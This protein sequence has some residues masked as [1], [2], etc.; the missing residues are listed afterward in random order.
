MGV[1][2]ALA[3]AGCSTLS[4]PSGPKISVSLALQHSP[5]APT[6]IR[7]DIGGQRVEVTSS[8]PSPGRSTDVRGRGYGATPV[9]VVLLTTDGDSLAAVA[10][11]QLFQRDH[12]HWVAALV[13]Q[14]R[15]V[16]HCIGTLVAAPLGAG[17]TDTLFVMYGS[18]PEGAVC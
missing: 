14:H 18:L 8:E 13:G 1:I 12:N 17:G 4:A 15:P 11:S 7:A 10:F 3:L 6:M 5:A 16:G 2:C 9:R